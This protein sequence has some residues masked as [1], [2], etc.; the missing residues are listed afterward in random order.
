VAGGLRTNGAG[1]PFNGGEIR[2]ALERLGWEIVE[3]PAE[4]EDP[5]FTHPEV[6][7][8]VHV[9]L[10]QDR[11][12]YGDTY[13]ETLARLMIPAHVLRDLAGHTRRKAIE[14]KMLQ[15]RSA[16]MAC[17]ELGEWHGS[18]VSLG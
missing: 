7:R 17:R 13:F 15:L 18:E 3:E 5:L 1:G 11:I 8:P 2:C 10:D 16:V 14:D 9:A 12:F 4:D 6:E